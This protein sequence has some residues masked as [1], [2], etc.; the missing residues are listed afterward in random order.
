MCPP[1]YQHYGFMAT[2]APVHNMYGYKL[3][4]SMNQTLLNKLS[5]ES[6]K[7]VIKVDVSNPRH[8]EC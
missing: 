4:I 1:G 2:H 5:K 7:N 6:N 8:T 3:L